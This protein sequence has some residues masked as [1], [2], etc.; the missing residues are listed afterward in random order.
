MVFRVFLFSDPPF[1]VPPRGGCMSPG[2]L[3]FSLYWR[4]VANLI[5]K[6]TYIFTNSSFKLLYPLNICGAGRNCI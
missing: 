4:I 3:G 1:I 6:C 2:L 5:P